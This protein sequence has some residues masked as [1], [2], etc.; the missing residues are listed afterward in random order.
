M[1]L[2]KSGVLRG[3][4]D[5]RSDAR[6]YLM[7]QLRQS[8]LDVVVRFLYPLLLDI[9]DMDPQVSLSLLFPSL[10]G[11]LPRGRRGGGGGGEPVIWPAQFGF[12][13]HFATHD[14]DAFRDGDL[15][16]GRGSGA[17]AAGGRPGAGAGDAGRF[18]GRLAAGI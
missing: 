5:Q 16:A 3:G 6:A 2:Q 13:A 15:S 9:A 17:V 10:G 11:D 18:W 8:S 7:H 12:A 4:S 1:A 14:V